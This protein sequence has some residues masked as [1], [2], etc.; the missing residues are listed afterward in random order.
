MESFVRS[1]LTPADIYYKLFS[2]SRGLCFTFGGGM[3]PVDTDNY[4]NAI[5]M[6][7]FLTCLHCFQ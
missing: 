6:H 4:V 5:F 7:I 1:K 3:R 2:V